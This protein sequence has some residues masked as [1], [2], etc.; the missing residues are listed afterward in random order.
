MNHTAL[1]CEGFCLL[2]EQECLL[3][4]SG[5]SDWALTSNQL[6]RIMNHTD[7]RPCSECL[8]LSSLTDDERA[9]IPT[10]QSFHFL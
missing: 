1:I 6:Q 5:Y 4:N 3:T 9:Q 10:V 7:H 8:N 2:N